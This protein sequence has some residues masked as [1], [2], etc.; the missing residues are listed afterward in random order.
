L[1]VRVKD[2][3]N[4]ISVKNVKRLSAKEESVINTIAMDLRSR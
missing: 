1:T 3:L 4:D 2:K